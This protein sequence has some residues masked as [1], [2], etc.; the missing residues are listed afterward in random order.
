MRPA[1]GRGHAAHLAFA[2]AASANLPSIIYNLFWLRFN[3]RGAT[4][5]IYG[6]LVSCV[7]LVLF[8]PLVSGTE[9]SLFVHHD[10]AWF[11]LS[12]PGI[13]SIPWASCSATSAP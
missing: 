5:S 12:N 6:C 9:T 4:W 10:F 11:P 8:S 3:T 7:V 13:V 2:V 1:A